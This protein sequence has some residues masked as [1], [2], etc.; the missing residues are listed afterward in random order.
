MTP[1]PSAD[2]LDGVRDQLEEVPDLPVER[3]VAV[4]ERANE[5]LASELSVLDEV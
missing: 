4:F 5:V 2:A 1:E 3:R